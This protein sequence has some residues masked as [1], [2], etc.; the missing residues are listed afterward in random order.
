MGQKQ[1]SGAS[2]FAANLG[3]S[4]YLFSGWLVLAFATPAIAG[5]GLNLI[6]FGIESNQL[7]GADVAT[8]GDTGALNTNPA[9]LSKLSGKT[10]DI[11]GAFG[12]ALGM[13]HRDTLGND[14]ETENKFIP[15]TDFGYAA[16]LENGVVWGVGAFAQGG[17]GNVYKDLITPFGTRDELSSQFRILKLSP[18]AAYRFTETLSV[19]FSVPIV[20]ADL[21][22][23]IFPETSVFSSAT[24]AQSF[25]GTKL[26]NAH[27]FGYGLR[28]GMQFYASDNLTLGATYAN[29][30]RLNLDRG[31][32]DVNM[33]AAGLGNVTYRDAKVQGL[34]LPQEV[35]LGI[36]FRLSD[37]WLVSLKVAWLDW[38]DALKSSTL[39]ASNPDNP[40]APSSISN[41]A[42]LNWRDQF[43][44][45]VG[46]AYRASEATSWS[47]GF[48]YGKNPIPNET[49]NPLLAAFAERH[50]T[51]GVRHKLSANWELAGGIEYDLPK[52]V[53]YTNPEQPFGPGAQ[54][55][56]E[57]IALHFGLSRRW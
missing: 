51:F 21:Q 46:V 11:H 24:P 7:A 57:L 34:A 3:F 4:A 27:G 14:A 56:G 35:G 39:T 43:V 26:S 55:R 2:F 22:Q 9:G 30:I 48:N 5:N 41:S 53:T 38:S 28:L 10:L 37:P 25:F 42:S 47:A 15:L 49:T 45:A 32:I 44:F 12:Y 13:R 40:A 31:K 20:F 54:E 16:R 19:G 8:A 50:V 18:G 17:S 29:K 6:G 52:T 36:A 33:S 1:I 23:K